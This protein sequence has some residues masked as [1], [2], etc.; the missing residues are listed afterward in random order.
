VGTG[1]SPSP[2]QIAA[3]EAA[4]LGSVFTLNR[5]GKR[6]SEALGRSRVAGAAGHWPTLGRNMEPER[7]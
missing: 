3:G 6:I 1:C 5:T 4:A 2:V 7:P